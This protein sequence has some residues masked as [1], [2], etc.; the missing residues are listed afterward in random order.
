MKKDYTF[1]V[2]S[3]F[4]PI[5]INNLISPN[6]NHIFKCLLQLTIMFMIRTKDKQC[7]SSGK[8][9]IALEV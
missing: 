7:G 1:Y 2:P 4:M 6:F 9:G 3:A 5:H 8:E